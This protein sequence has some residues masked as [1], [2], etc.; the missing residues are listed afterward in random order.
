MRTLPS[1]RDFLRQLA[2]GLGSF[3]LA[4]LL[5]A[6]AARARGAGP[7]DPPPHH[8]PR[9]KRVIYMNMVGGASHV[10]LLDPKP[11]LR[12]R[13]G[14]VCPESLYSPEK[15]AFIRSRPTLFGSPFEFEAVGRS[16]VQVS[17]L[18]PHLKEI[19]DDVAIVRSMRTDEFNH[20]PA[21]L[22]QLTGYSRF[23]RPSFGAWASFG[24]GTENEDLPAYV[25]LTSGQIP[26]AGSAVWGSGFLPSSHAG[27]HF[28][29]QGD[30][31]LFLSNPPEISRAGRR[32]QI[33]LVNELNGLRHREIG[34]PEIEARMEQFELAFRMQASVPTAV[35][36]DDEP[37]EVLELYGAERDR[38]SFGRNCIL[39]RRLIE[40]GVRFVQ[41]F[42]SDW[43]HH[44]L[45]SDQL[46]S[47]CKDVD[48]GS[49]ALV[50]DLKRRG[51]LDDTLV[52]WTTEFGRTPMV[53]GSDGT[54]EVSLPGRDHHQDA[55]SMWLAGGGVS[56]GLVYGATDEFGAEVTENPVHVHDLNATLLW[57][58][59]I[60]HKRLTYDFQ[61]RD[62]RLTDVHGEVVS[63][64]MA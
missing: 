52:V 11:V 9:A 18:L 47:K 45:L 15:L 54:G 55:F 59:G 37:D 43:D 3:V 38:E 25:V 29:S 16:G 7:A 49:A 23:G 2:G 51:L 8:A 22:L 27:V 21:Q 40:R 35:D 63:A 44:A 58:L 17:E 6:D 19:V 46:P 53:Q 39:A 56:P 31:V 62:F 34:D 36:L 30:P 1:R 64:L 10:D 13:H 24:L 50:K 20:G 48:R 14:E 4:D 5:G 28:R 42:D 41:L 26:G 32:R 57:L 61:G 12:T 33:E 60:D